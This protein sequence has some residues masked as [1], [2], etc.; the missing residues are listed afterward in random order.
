MAHIYDALKMVLQP[1][2]G[3]PPA[4]EPVRCTFGADAMHAIPLA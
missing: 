3:F 1:T 4:E 2:F